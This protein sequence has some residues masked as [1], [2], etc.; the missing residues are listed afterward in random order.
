MNDGRR[1]RD[2]QWCNKHLD[3]FPANQ[4]YVGKSGKGKGKLSYWCIPCFKAYFRERYAN[5]AVHRA[6]MKAT[7]KEQASIRSRREKANG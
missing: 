2:L 7:A 6:T 4:F 5:D 1:L 3:Y